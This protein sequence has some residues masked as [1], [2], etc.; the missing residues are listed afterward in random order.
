M[1]KFDNLEYSICHFIIIHYKYKIVF[2]ILKYPRF[3]F[4][5]IG[6]YDTNELSTSVLKFFFF[7]HRLTLVS[8]N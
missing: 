4:V 1:F 8:N 6:L 5:Y 3:T 7:N 2:G